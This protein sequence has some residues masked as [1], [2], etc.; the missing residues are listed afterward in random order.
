LYKEIF[1]VYDNVA[2]DRRQRYQPVSLLSSMDRHTL[3]RRL[4][5]V[6]SNDYYLEEYSNIHNQ[7][8]T[9]VELEEEHQ[10]NSG[11]EALV[12]THDS[13]T[14][15]ENTKEELVEH[16]TPL[17]TRTLRNSKIISNIDSTTVLNTS[18][19]NYT[20]T[21]LSRV[22]TNSDIIVETPLASPTDDQV[23]QKKKV[24]KTQGAWSD[25]PTPDDND[26]EHLVVVKHGVLHNALRGNKYI[27]PSSD[28]PDDTVSTKCCIIL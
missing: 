28:D 13:P 27:T 15:T 12:K 2:E 19:S 3:H 18:K 4:S 20:P 25:T 9:N 17:S 24:V 10:T 7:H 6:D 11:D 23:S 26:E 1:D 14:A 22:G 5:D 21:K 16:L 8:T